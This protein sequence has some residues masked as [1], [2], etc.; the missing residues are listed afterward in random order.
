MTDTLTIIVGIVFVVC[1]I[2][3][4]VCGGI[5]LAAITEPWDDDTDDTDGDAR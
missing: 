3:V 5:F 2:T 4:G 1:L